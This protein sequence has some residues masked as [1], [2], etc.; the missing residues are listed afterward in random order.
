[1]LRAAIVE[2]EKE[3]GDPDTTNGYTLL[4][5]ILQAQGKLEDARKERSARPGRIVANGFFMGN[6]LSD[7]KDL[8]IPFISNDPLS[9]AASFL[10]ARDPGTI[11]KVTGVS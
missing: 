2:F 6:S 8:L 1:M 11:V 3:K 9:L 10:I 7:S 5:R 4:S